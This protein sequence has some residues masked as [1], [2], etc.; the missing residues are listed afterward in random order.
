LATVG[1][2]EERLKTF[3]DRLGLVNLAQALVPESVQRAFPSESGRVAIQDVDIDWSQ[4]KA[5][6]LGRGPIYV[7]DGAFD[8]SA[9]KNDYI[10]ELTDALT[11]LETPAGDPVAAE[12]H[13]PAD[14]YTGQLYAAP[15]L[16]V[17]YT[18]GVDAPESIGGEVFGETTEW[19]ATHRPTGIFAAWGD[20]IATGTA[21][22]SLYDLAPTLLH[23]LDS[24]VPKD[25]DGDVRFDI[26][27]RP[28]VDRDVT[29]GAPTA[30]AHD[31]TQA[32][33]DVEDT[34]RELGYLE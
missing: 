34:L 11:T 31:G 30:T 5:V 6:S 17:E 9:A 13:D 8:D 26:L 22:L 3:V 15:D 1:L 33:R 21:N 23:Y 12:V 16:V 27:T 18:T 29:V 28:A 14:I 10:E 19:L 24:P 2:T 20:R 7:N 25:M 32:D 4:T